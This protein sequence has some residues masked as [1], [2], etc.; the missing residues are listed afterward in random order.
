MTFIETPLAKP[1]F[2]VP[3]VGTV[4]TVVT[5]YRDAYIHS[6]TGWKD[7]VYKNVTVVKPDPWTKP[8]SFCIPA[9]DHPYLTKRTLSL[10]N[11]VDL[12]THGKKG[13]A[14]TDS[15]TEFVEIAGSKG[16][17]YTVTVVSGFGKSCICPGFT[18]RKQC[19]HLAMASK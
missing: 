12:T 17:T 19:K 9:E 14:H 5:R 16:N 3:Q 18:Y 4:I 15:K 8:D 11:V 1:L 7:N 2:A 10:D 6:E 13:K